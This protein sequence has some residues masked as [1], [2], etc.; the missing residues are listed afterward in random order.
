VV[1]FLVFADGGENAVVHHQD[2]EL[3]AVAHGRGDFLA[4]HHEAAVTG[5]GDD[6][7]PGVCEGCCHGCGDSHAHGAV[8]GCGQGICRVVVQVACGP[9]RVVP[10]TE[11]QDGVGVH[12]L[13]EDLHG[14]AQVDADAAVRLRRGE[15]ELVG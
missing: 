10:G 8:A 12:L 5:N 11:G 3:G 6:L 1:R 9:Q 2:D 7:A 15:R 13:L 4:V 14:D